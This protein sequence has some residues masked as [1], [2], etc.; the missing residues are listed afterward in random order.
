MASCGPVGN[1]PFNVSQA[2]ATLARLTKLSPSVESHRRL[3][4][5]QTLLLVSSWRPFAFLASLREIKE[6]TP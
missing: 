4:T 5:I 2:P 3:T 1:W 6:N